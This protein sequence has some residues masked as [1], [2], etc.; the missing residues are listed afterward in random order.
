M[1]AVPNG[2]CGHQRA[3]GTRSSSRRGLARF[4][5]G[6]DAV[7]HGIAHAVEEAA[8][9]MN[10]APALSVLTLWV[11]SHG[12]EVRPRRIVNRRGIPRPHDVCL[13]PVAEFILRTRAAP[14]TG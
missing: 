13:A 10:V 9:P 6:M 8:T 11:A 3:C 4:V 1:I 12:K 2:R 7:G 14:R 5:R